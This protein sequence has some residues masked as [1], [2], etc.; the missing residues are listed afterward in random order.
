MPGMKTET[1]RSLAAAGAALIALVTLATLSP[2]PQLLVWYLTNNATMGFGMGFIVA[3][4]YSRWAAP[5]LMYYFVFEL[6]WSVAAAG[7]ATFGIGA[8][9]AVGV[10]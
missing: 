3:G 10:G 5:A 7:L 4:L 9:I 8:I 2:L 1:R 6:G